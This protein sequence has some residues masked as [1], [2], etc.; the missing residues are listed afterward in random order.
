MKTPVRLV[1]LLL[2]SY[3]LLSGCAGTHKTPVSA[4]QVDKPDELA[5]AALQLY[6]RQKNTAQAL[7]LL[8]KATKEAPQRAE[9]R[10]LQ[11]QVCAQVLDCNT[12]VLEAEL[13]KLAPNNGAVQLGALAR[14]Q[15]EGNNT[16]AAS[17][18]D[19]ISR[20]PSFQIYWNTLLSKLTRATLTQ[21]GKR[22]QPVTRSLNEITDWYSTL[23]SATFGPLLVSCSAERAA[24]DG[25]VNS[26]C[27]RIAG[28]LLQSDT[29]IAESVGLMLA[30]RLLGS[31]REAQILERTEASQY[32]REAASQVINA[33][34]DREK[35]STQLI[36]LMAKVPREQDVFQAIVRWGGRGEDALQPQ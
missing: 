17:V 24:A 8:Q 15:R 3:L 22:P 6:F 5:A 25:Y 10:W 7:K 2:G 30:R 21:V 29:Y 1:G 14:A 36:E 18:L 12:E 20:S 16:A 19:A 33:Q 9:I 35:F 34:L 28:L 4:V 26:R 23:A 31:D 32:Q 11:F 13:L 27:I